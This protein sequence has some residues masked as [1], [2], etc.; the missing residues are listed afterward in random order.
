MLRIPRPIVSLLAVAAFLFGSMPAPAQSLPDKKEVSEWV[1][2]ALDTDILQSPDA[3]PFH[4]LATVRYTFNGKSVDGTYEVMW[5]AADRFRVEFRMGDVTETDLILGDKK[6]VDRNT[7]TMTMLMWSISSFLFPEGRKPVPSLTRNDAVYKLTATGEGATRQI[8]AMVGDHKTLE[9]EMCFSATTRDLTSHRI[10]PLRSMVNGAISIDLTD[11]ISF[12][13]LRYP[14]HLFKQFGTEM[15]YATVERWEA[16][17]KFDSKLFAP[18]PNSI[19]WDWCSTPEVHRPKTTQNSSF[20]S[21]IMSSTGQGQFPY[22]GVYKIV[23]QDGTPKQVTQL[24]RSPE[25]AAKEFV[26]EQRRERSAVHIC[27][28]KPVEYETIVAFFPTILKA[29]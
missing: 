10:H 8:C 19:A 18:L 26:N 23:G 14:Q 7:P 1:T 22:V 29:Q 16:V 3:S 6:Y 25:S 12:G 11:Y 9:N 2:K 17:E 24:F 4:F 21:A 27:N 13:K 28:G 5:Q 20:I 15:I